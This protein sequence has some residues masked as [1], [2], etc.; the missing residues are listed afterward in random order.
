MK[1]ESHMLSTSGVPSFEGWS[2]EHLL[3]SLVTV[4]KHRERILMRTITDFRD[5]SAVAVHSVGIQT[6]TG[7]ESPPEVFEEEDNI[8]STP[9]GAYGE[10]SAVGVG[11]SAASDGEL[12]MLIIMLL[13][14]T[15]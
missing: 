2:N 6:H 13:D 7:D 1:M 9:A 4:L 5:K 14:K 3:V 15:L 10:N 12:K 8:E 11:V